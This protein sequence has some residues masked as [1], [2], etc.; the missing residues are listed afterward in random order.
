VAWAF[1]PCE[2]L[3]GDLLNLFPVGDGHLGLYLLDVSGHGVPASLLAVAVGHALNPHGDPAGLRRPAEVVRRVNER[4]CGDRAEQFVTLFYGVLDQDTCTLT[5]ANAGHPG[6]IL[7]SPGA[8]PAVLTEGGLMAGVTA[9]AEY[10]AAEVRLRSGDRLWVYS[11]GLP[12]AMNPAGE[13]F[14]PTRLSAAFRDAGVKLSDAVRAVLGVVERWTG[15]GGP[16]DDV[17]VVALEVGETAGGE[18]HADSR[19]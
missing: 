11:D 19:D 1:R 6:P 16:Q 2:E 7:L 17:S 3:G 14:G 18:E 10:R 15:S 8:D 13:P 12:E 9:E 5:Y 4:L